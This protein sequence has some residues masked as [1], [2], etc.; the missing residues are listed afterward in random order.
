MREIRHLLI[1]SD[2]PNLTR[3]S[4]TTLQVNLGYLCNQSCQHCHVDAG[5]HRQELMGDDT[6]ELLFQL[7]SN[8]VV[9]SLDLTGGAPEMHPRFA[10]LVEHARACGVSVT[11]RC[12]LTILEEPG[13]EYLYDFLA[14]NEVAVVASLPCYTAENVDYQRGR[15]TFAKSIL[16]LRTLNRCGYGDG[17]SGLIL[18]LVYNPLGPTLPPPQLELEKRYK[19][20]LFAA[21]GIK[22]DRLLAL[23]NMP[24]KRFG[25]MLESKGK[26]ASYVDLL[27]SAHHPENLDSV[28]CRQMLSVDWRGY[29]YDCDFNQMLDLPLGGLTERAHLK[30]LM[31]EQMEGRPISVANHC[32]GCTAGQGSSCSG[33]LT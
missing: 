10:D 24:I 21:Y 4:L 7:F 14:D 17:V 6:I 15:G 25:S 27:R 12:N 29:L 30:H 3:R 33:A 28:M 23:T 32:W 22:F 2:F 31:T 18:N 8:G 26:F 5:P 16:A 19:E 11:D 13:F 9:K 1:P 20:E